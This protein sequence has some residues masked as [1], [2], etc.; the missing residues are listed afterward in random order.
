MGSGLCFGVM[1]IFT[2]KERGMVS[3]LWMYAVPLNFFHFKGVNFLF[4]EF[5]LNVFCL[6]FAF[7]GL[8]PQHMEVPR[9]GVKGEL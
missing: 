6:F 7:L 1:A 2:T 9:P 4:H 5:R 3:Q 8:H